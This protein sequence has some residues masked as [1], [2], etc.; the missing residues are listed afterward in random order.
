[1]AYS[2]NLLS[3]SV[4]F[5]VL[6]HGCF[7]DPFRSEQ[8]QPQKRFQT[9]CQLRNLNALKPQHRFR[10]EA[11]LTEFWDQNEEQ[12]Q[13]AAVAFLRHKIQPHGLLLPSFNNA[14]QLVYVVQGLI[15]I[16][17]FSF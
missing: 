17:M 6:F 1:M 11:G 3:L 13:C 12:F 10:S 7:A 15:N 4:C 8:Q 9:Q 5:L 16:L 14:P 2:S